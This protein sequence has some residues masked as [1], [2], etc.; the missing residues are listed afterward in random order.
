M[1]EESYVMTFY[2]THMALEFERVIDQEEIPGELTPVPRK[3]SSSCGL[4]GKFAEND[5]DKVKS[6]CQTE[7]IEFDNVYKVY[8]DKSKE[9]EEIV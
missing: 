9:P 1:S 2:S 8:A 5:L 6:L 3:I 7:G 4:A